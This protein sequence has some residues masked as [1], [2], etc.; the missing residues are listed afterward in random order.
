MNF[1][2]EESDYDV[3]FFELKENVLTDDTG[4][5]AHHR[6]ACLIRPDIRKIK[7]VSNDVWLTCFDES[8]SGLVGGLAEPIHA[9]YF[10]SMKDLT[11]FVS[12]LN[13]ADLQ[14]ITPIALW[15]G[16]HSQA[17]PEYGD[18][19]VGYDVV[20]FFSLSGI[21]CFVRDSEEMTELRRKYA[22]DLNNGHLFTEFERAVDFSRHM[23]SWSPEHA[24][25]N[26]VGIF[27]LSFEN[28][29]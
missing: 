1:E 25:F 12:G 17:P 15:Y 14:F 28:L 21:F 8:L 2:N 23:D 24:P 27:E 19:F 11:D 29:N 5:T 10:R 20:D 9:D 7:S 18:T 26:P 6:E 16:E 4:W 3:Y 22:S 13:A